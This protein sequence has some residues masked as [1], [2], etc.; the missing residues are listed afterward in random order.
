MLIVVAVV[1]SQLLVLLL[2][3]ALFCVGCCFGRVVAVVGVAVV[4]GAV[5]C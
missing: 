1:L 4:V 3:L 2:S 5:L